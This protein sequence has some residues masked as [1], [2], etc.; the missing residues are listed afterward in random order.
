MDNETSK[1]I[2]EGDRATRFLL[3]DEWLW[4]KEKLNSILQAT[5]SISLL[6]DGNNEQVGEEAKV[7]KKASQLILAWVAELE[8]LSEVSK[9][10]KNIPNEPP[11]ILNIND[12]DNS[13]L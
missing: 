7:R 11:L 1:Q 13:N 5:D 9:A 2:E 6:P 10:Y 12:K 4:A 3:S 8:G